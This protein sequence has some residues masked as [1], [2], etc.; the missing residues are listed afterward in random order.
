MAFCGKLSSFISR[1]C[2]NVSV[3]PPLP[4]LNVKRVLF[5]VAAGENVCA[6]SETAAN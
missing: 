4:L 6:A 2:I 5:I 3:L 1:H